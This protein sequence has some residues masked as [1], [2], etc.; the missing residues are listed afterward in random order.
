MIALCNYDDTAQVHQILKQ[1]ERALV[2]YPNINFE[3]VES[4][5]FLSDK[6]GFKSDIFADLYLQH[7]LDLKDK[8]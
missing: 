5:C 7:L 6:Y 4:H 2:F 1:F 3:K 8:L